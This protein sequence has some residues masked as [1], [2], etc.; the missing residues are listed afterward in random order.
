MCLLWGICAHAQASETAQGSFPLSQGTM[1]TYAGL[2]RW[3]HAGT[4]EVSETKVIWK[5]EVL[6]VI[7][8]NGLSVAVIRGFPGDLDW[9][10]G[11]PTPGDSLIIRSVQDRFY[12]ISSDNSADALRRLDD[13]K[14]SLSGLL[15][16]DNLF[17]GLP[18]KA[19]SKFCDADGMARPDGMYCWVVGAPQR[20]SLVGVRGAATREATAYTVEYRT[21]PDDTE[22]V[23]VPGI[24]VVGYEYH[25]HGTVADTVLKLA[26]FHPGH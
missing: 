24:G 13:A 17:F 23:F 7:H 6:R 21:A 15:S 4:N 10:D 11:R 2:V 26:E 12:I 22:F 1:W 3:T 5:T 8:R 19:G 9:S 14:D 16:D 25:H 20:H 18:I